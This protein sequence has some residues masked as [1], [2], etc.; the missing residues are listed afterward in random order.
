MVVLPTARVETEVLTGP[1]QEHPATDGYHPTPIGT[2]GS[3]RM[4]RG[5]DPL[6][7]VTVIATDRTPILLVSA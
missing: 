1:D 5:Y 6:P 4:V 3:R 2:R 7:W